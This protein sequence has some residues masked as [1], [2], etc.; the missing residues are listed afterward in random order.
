MPD[1]ELLEA[2][3]AGARRRCA[4]VEVGILVKRDNS[5]GV[6][7]AEDVA[8]SAAVMASGEIVEVA[9]AGWVVTDGG[10]RIGLLNKVAS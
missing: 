7:V 9:L 2:V 4:G 3:V 5:V 6:R 8:T 1:L 10:L